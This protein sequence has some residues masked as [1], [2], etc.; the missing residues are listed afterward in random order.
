MNDKKRND[1]NEENINNKEKQSISNE[2]INSEET[3][4]TNN[5]KN[6]ND[7]KKQENIKKGAIALS[8]RAKDILEWIYCIVIAVVLAILIKYYIGTP[9]VVKMSSMYPTLEQ[10]DRLILSRINKTL[11]KL[12]DRGDII[13]FEEP[14][15][16]SSVSEI[17]MENPVAKYENEP[18]GWWNKFVYYVLEI[19]KTSYIKR[20][21]GLPGEHVEIKDYKVYI[22]G[23]ELPEDYLDPSVK[24]PATGPFYDFVVPENCVFAM[25][26]NRENSTDCR[27][28]GCIPLERIESK[29]VLRFFPFNKFGKVK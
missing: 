26:D 19:N 10:S 17:D 12:P 24:T 20:V 9:T 5:V 27:E 15:R 18:Q 14:T 6:Q 22:N 29:V 21:I 23:T 13:T 16:S 1:N 11:K 7:D 25:G 3:L 2:K 4:N 28:F 8:A